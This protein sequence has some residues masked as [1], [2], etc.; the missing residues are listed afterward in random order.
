MMVREFAQIYTYFDNPPRLLEANGVDEMEPSWSDFS[1]AYSYVMQLSIS[2][3][4]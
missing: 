2:I 3:P 1:H 4:S